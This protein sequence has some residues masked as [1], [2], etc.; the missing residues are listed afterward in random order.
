MTMNT[1]TSY[2]EGVKYENP[3]K[4]VYITHTWQLSYR[5]GFHE[6]HK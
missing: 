6:C 1:V 5:N 3:D 4:F 2:C